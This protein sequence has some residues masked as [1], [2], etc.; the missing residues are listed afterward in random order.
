MTLPHE[1]ALSYLSALP[2]TRLSITNLLRNFENV[3]LLASA[4][5]KAFPGFWGDF[6]IAE[7]PQEEVL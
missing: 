3:T 2:Q 5:E 1:Q 6:L 4:T 7:L